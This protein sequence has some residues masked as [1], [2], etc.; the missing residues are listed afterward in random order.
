MRLESILGWVFLLLAFAIY[1]SYGYTSMVGQFFNG[2]ALG[3]FVNS[4]YKDW[5]GIK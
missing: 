1:Y 2:M 5:K 3:F 4:L